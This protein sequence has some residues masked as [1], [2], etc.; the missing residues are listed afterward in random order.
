MKTWTFFVAA[1]TSLMHLYYVEDK[2]TIIPGRERFWGT[3][4]GLPE[5][6]QT[7]G[8]YVEVQTW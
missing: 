7:Q 6:G 4:K 1:I 3:R 8:I 2:H 5:Q